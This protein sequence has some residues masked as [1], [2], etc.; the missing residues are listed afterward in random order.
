MKKFNSAIKF[1]LFIVAFVYAMYAFLEWGAV[2]KFIMSAAYRQLERNGMR[3][4][5]SDV[6]GEEGGFTVNNLA[7]SGLA[8]ISLSSI[9][10]KPQILSSLLSLAPVCDITFTDANVRLGQNLHLGDG[11][12]LMTAGRREIFLENLRTNGDFALNGYL[13]VNLA[14]MKLGR[15]DARLNIPDSFAQNMNMLKGFLPLVQEGG[16]WYLRRQ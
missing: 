9:T 2:G 15:T 13:T 10:I 4:S 12:F 16:R 14:T 6:T 3:M 11:G 5:Y 8:N 1:L 7:L